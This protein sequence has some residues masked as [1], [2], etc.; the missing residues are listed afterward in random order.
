[1]EWTCKSWCCQG[2]FQNLIN[3]KFP[4]LRQMQQN[5]DSR[6]CDAV[7]ENAPQISF[8]LQIKDVV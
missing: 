5:P 7:D 3:L 6:G 4:T 2:Y 8:G 1:M